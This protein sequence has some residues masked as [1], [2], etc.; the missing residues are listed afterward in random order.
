[1]KYSF[2]CIKNIYECYQKACL[3][4]IKDSCVPNVCRFTE[5]CNPLAISILQIVI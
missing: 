5:N 1:M 3:V 2:C 4:E